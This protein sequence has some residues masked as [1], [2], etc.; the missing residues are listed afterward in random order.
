MKVFEFPHYYGRNRDAFWDC[1]TD[2]VDPTEVFV[3]NFDILNDK[4]RL[5]VADYLAMLRDCE[6]ESNGEFSVSFGP[7]SQTFLGSSPQ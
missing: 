3:I 7:P 4:L 2:I 6:A 1:I 5:V